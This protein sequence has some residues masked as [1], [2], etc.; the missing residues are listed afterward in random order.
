[1]ILQFYPQYTTIVGQIMLNPHFSWSK[2]AISRR[3]SPQVPRTSDRWRL[4]SQGHETRSE[5]VQRKC[6]DRPRWEEGPG[7]DDFQGFNH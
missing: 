4:K 7:W 2:P 1:M 5:I 6:G 3:V